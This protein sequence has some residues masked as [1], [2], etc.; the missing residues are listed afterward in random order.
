M[1]R[2]IDMARDLGDAIQKDDRYIQTMSAQRAAD[3]DKELQNLIGEFNLKRIA[4]NNEMQKENKKDAKIDALSTEVRD[5]YDKIMNNEAMKQYNTVKPELDHLVN[6]VARI[7]TLASQGEDPYS[8]NESDGG[9][10]GNCSACGGC[11]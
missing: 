11:N 4:L 2:I 1:D 5:V 9:C 3:E 10:S 8:I 7:I 6:A